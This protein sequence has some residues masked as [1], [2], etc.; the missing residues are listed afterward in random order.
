MWQGMELPYSKGCQHWPCILSCRYLGGASWTSFCFVAASLRFALETWVPFPL[1]RPLSA[2]RYRDLRGTGLP[3][4][5][6]GLPRDRTSAL[7]TESYH[8]DP[9]PV[10]VFRIPSPEVLVL[11]V[12]V[13]RTRFIMSTA[14]SPLQPRYRYAA[15]RPPPAAVL[16]PAVGPGLAGPRAAPRR[17]WPR[18]P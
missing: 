14:L 12:T 4:H 16:A 15:P 1:Q 6:S 18:S 2:C 17:C 11:G 8:L 10:E 9:Y 7:L 3:G 5:G 13:V